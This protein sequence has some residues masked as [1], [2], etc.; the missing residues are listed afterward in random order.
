MKTNIKFILS[1]TAIVIA[2][3]F[4]VAYGQI[5]SEFKNNRYSLQANQQTRRD[6]VKLETLLSIARKYGLEK[7]M[8]WEPFAENKNPERPKTVVLK[9]SLE[10]FEEWMKQTA[11]NERRVEILTQFYMNDFQKVSTVKEYIALKRAYAKKYP[12]YLK[13]EKAFQESEIQREES[14]AD[15]IVLNTPGYRKAH[16][17]PK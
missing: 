8:I 17:Q 5:K 3:F 4:S 16:P 7:K 1:I 9:I 13:N 10:H 14:V 6:T 15:Q 12:E 11:F 2:V